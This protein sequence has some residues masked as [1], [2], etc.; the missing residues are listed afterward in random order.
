MFNKRKKNFVLNF[1]VVGIVVASICAINFDSDKISVNENRKLAGFPILYNDDRT[2]HSD[3]KQNFES[4]LKDNIG[5]RD[6]FINISSSIQYNVLHK[7]PNKQVAIGEDGWMF[8]T[9]DNNLGIVMGEYS[10][11][12]ELL[13]E[14]GK[15]QK[16]LQAYFKSMGKEYVL[17]LPV[18]KASIYPEKL[19]G[20]MYSVGKSPV[21]IVADYVEENTDIHV[22]RLKESLLEE[23]KTTQVFFKTDSHWNEEGAYIAYKKII[24]DFNNWG[25]INSSPKDVEYSDNYR[26]GEFSALMG[27]VKLLPPEKYRAT[28]IIGQRAKMIT[29]GP[30]AQKYLDIKEKMNYFEMYHYENEFVEDKKLLVFGD[31]MFAYW[32]IPQLLAENFSEYTYCRV[33]QTDFQNEITAEI[34]EAVNPDIVALE[35][36]ERYIDQLGNELNYVNLSGA[37]ENPNAEILS[38]DIPKTLKE[39]EVCDIRVVVKNSGGSS[40]KN[41]KGTKLCIWIDGNDYGYRIELSD[42]VAVDSGEEFTFILYNFVMPQQDNVTIEFQML[43]EGIQYFGEKEGGT[44]DKRQ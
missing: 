39:N 1:V 19:A 23:K 18:S 27:N 2:L 4:W 44:I 3:I 43:Q 41:Y 36:T 29:E 24:Q 12:H 6:T 26:A 30:I 17:I 14:I 9:E 5:F 7:S 10:I 33:V 22:V 16:K 20:D 38:C 11:N 8:Y 32:N 40:W 31:S 25:F 15:T 42:G 34:I 28:N 13:E 37:L 21:D 35:I